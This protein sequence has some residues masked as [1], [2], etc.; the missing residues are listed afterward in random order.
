MGYY[1][2]CRS[3]VRS[4]HGQ[5]HLRNRR[6][7]PLTGRFFIPSPTNASSPPRNRSCDARRRIW[8]WKPALLHHASMRHTENFPN[9][10][11]MGSTDPERSIDSRSV[12]QWKRSLSVSD[13]SAILDIAGDL[14][15]RVQNLG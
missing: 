11:A 7:L 9:K 6:S 2:E 1:E 13:V 5:R 12:G 10:L 8:D 15:V 3:A 14:N 4:D